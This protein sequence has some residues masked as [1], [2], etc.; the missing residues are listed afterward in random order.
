MADLMTAP[1]ALSVTSVGLSVGSYIYTTKKHSEIIE[2]VQ[3]LK[4]TVEKIT[5][6]VQ[7]IDP[8]L[9]HKLEKRVEDIQRTF[10]LMSNHIGVLTHKSNHHE[11]NFSRLI[12]Y[13]N[14][15]LTDFNFPTSAQ[16]QV[17]IKKTVEPQKVF[18]PRSI[19]LPKISLITEEDDDDDDDD[20]SQIAQMACKPKAKE[21]HNIFEESSGSNKSPI[22]VM[23]IFQEVMDDEDDISQIARM[24]SSQSVRQNF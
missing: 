5:A 22:K 19:Q 16:P 21:I 7:K 18:V 17:E 12:E 2:V 3:D 6:Y 15:N 23:D 9:T 14:T 10:Q 4:N 20:I 13:L 8:Q 24:A 1:G 11:Q